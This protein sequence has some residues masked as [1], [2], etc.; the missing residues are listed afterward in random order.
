MKIALCILNKNEAACLKVML[1]M[2]PKPGPTSGVDLIVAIDGNSTDGSPDILRAHGVEVV[3]QSA[4]GRGQAFHTAFAKVDADAFVFFSPDGNEDP[5][6]L[7]RFRELLEAGADVVIASRMMP[8]A[9]N[10][11]DVHW[12]RPRK[13]VNNIFNHLANMI[14]RKGDQPY[15]TDSING[16]RAI[17]REAAGRLKLDAPDYTIEYQM[18]MRALR[19]GLRIA[20]FPT[21]EGQRIAGE[22]GAPSFPT[23]VRFIKRFWKEAYDM[24]VARL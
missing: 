10:E 9:F 8:G 3:G 15:I 4:L 5:R 23:G 11:E 1:P 2:L 24:S 6:D 17:T 14:F 20:E 16:Y 22:T 12:F 18:T 21:H 13:W 7:P 19:N